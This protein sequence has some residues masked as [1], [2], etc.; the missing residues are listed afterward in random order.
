MTA[1]LKILVPEATV[2][3]VQN[4]EFRYDTTGW[5]G[6]SATPTRTL[7]CARFGI[8]S[9]KVVTV[10]SIIAEG[11]YYRVNYLNG[12]RDNVSASAYVRGDGYVRIRLLEASSGVEY[13]SDTI[14]LQNDRWVR[15]EASG[16]CSC[17][18][19]V[20]LY[21]ETV[22]KRITT[23]YVDGGQVEIKF[24]PTS[25]CDGEQGG[26][27]WDNVAHGSFSLR[28]VYSREGG[29]WVNVI[30]NNSDYE[31]IYA[32]MT[33][34]FGVETIT[35]NRVSN[36]FAPGGYINNIKK[37]ERLLSIVFHVKNKNLARECDKQLSLS[38]LHNLRQMLIDVIKPDAVGGDQP[39]WLEYQ[40]GDVPVRIMAYYDGGL[41][42]DWDIRNQWA[43]D[44]PLRLLSTTPFFV[45]D[46]Q[47]CATFDFSDTKLFSGVAGRID[48]AW[49]NMNG[50]IYNNYNT[51]DFPDDNEDGW[52]QDMA[53][54]DRGEIYAV[55]RFS[56]INYNGTL[57]PNQPADCA[58][59]WDGYRWTAF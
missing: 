53:M 14:T 6:H 31:D 33:T 23:F 4:P 39:F 26:C 28:D 9:L 55:G 7:D 48:G 43:M 1:S 25:F 17:S 16:L 37:N 56:K 49:N 47:E 30:G 52:V 10:G 46:N 45:E 29:R 59:Y 50:G 15:I 3:F 44:F 35:N 40:D 27:R 18:S 41:E 11:V 54:G 2:N 58:A 22:D 32:T 34:G 24:L 12:T 21:V 42:G 38:K 8:A 5:Y 20:R 51:A 19:D 13:R 57:S 36:V